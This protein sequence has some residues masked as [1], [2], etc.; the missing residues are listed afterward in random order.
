MSRFSASLSATLLP[1][2]SSE[3]DDDDDDDDDEDADAKYVCAVD[4]V[5]VAKAETEA[6]PEP[7]FSATTALVVVDD[8][9]MMSAT[10]LSK[11]AGRSEG[12]PLMS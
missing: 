3:I 7:P 4:V 5:A 8:G 2:F 10:S 12:C 6:S 9:F 11:V 1:S